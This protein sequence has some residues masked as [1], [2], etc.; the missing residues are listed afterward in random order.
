MPNERGVV[1]VNRG[2]ELTFLSKCPYLYELNI[3]RPPRRLLH[4][5]VDFELRTSDSEQTSSLDQRMVVV[6]VVLGAERGRGPGRVRGKKIYL[7]TN[8]AE[9]HSYP[10]FIVFI[11]LNYCGNRRKIAL[12]QHES[13]LCLQI[14]EFSIAVLKK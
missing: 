9:F 5:R 14:L 2:H 12:S 11:S 1:D 8:G 7:Y 6:V 13:K 4:G 3:F 10:S